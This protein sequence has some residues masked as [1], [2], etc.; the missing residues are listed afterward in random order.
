MFDDAS[1]LKGTAFFL[2]V[3]VDEGAYF[4]D[5]KGK[6]VRILTIYTQL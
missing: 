4:Y 3:E 5:R 1:L 2:P 6:R